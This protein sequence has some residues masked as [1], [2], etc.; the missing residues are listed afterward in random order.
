MNTNR[1]VTRAL[2]G[3][4]GV[5]IQ[6]SAFCPTNFF[7]NQLSLEF[8]VD[9]K[10]TSSGRTQIY[11]YSSPPP[12]PLS[13]YGPEYKTFPMQTHSFMK[14]SNNNILAIIPRFK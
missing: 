11:E 6:I 3:G 12:L 4:G 8:K 14:K 5:N 13:S 7:S 10:R 2:I 1:A 9:F